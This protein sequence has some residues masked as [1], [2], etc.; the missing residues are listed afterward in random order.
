MSPRTTTVDQ[1]IDE[2]LA[3][4]VAAAGHAPSILNT[5]PW[6]WRVHPDGLELFAERSR[7]LAAG[8]A[9][10]RQLTLSSGTALHH[11]TV[12]LT[13][14]GWAVQV[15]RLPDTGQPDL[16][17]KLL[18]TGRITADAA[19]TRLAQ[20]IPDRRTDRRPVSDQPLPAASMD[21]I[22]AAARAHTRLHVLTPDQILLLASAAREAAA[23]QADDPGVAAELAYW[24]DP[25][26]PEGTGV[27]AGV[28]PERPP[29]T[30]VPGRGFG[31]AGTLPIGPGH[32]RAAV[33]VL[34][35]A[36]S[37]EPRSWLAS[38]EA[39]SAAWLTATALGVSVVPLNDVIEVVHAR[40]ILRR[41]LAGLGHPHLV[42]RLGIA[43]P[44]PRRHAAQTPRLTI[45]QIMDTSTQRLT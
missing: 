32:D 36:D 7:Q 15:V 24:T 28:L 14:A 10:A 22:A 31:R 25:A 21:T 40:Q 27:P 12:S 45:P 41:I 18:V 11:A 6:R 5:Q 17:A 13:A 9:Q 37:D 44:E 34:L 29:Q 39:L 23:V 33:Y 30:T 35:F 26:A 3:Q 38:G 8:D 42:L 4:A 2:A 19:A 20:V 16:L 1:P 43:D